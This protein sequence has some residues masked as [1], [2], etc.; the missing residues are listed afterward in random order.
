M[1]ATG[2]RADRAF[3][4]NPYLAETIFPPARAAQQGRALKEEFR[5]PPPGEEE[6]DAGVRA[7]LVPHRG[8]ADAGRSKFRPQRAGSWCGRSTRSPRTQ[9]ARG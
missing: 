4:G 3:A 1:P 7:A 2:A 6:E 8:A 9:R 5:L